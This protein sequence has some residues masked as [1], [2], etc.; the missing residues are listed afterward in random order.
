MD[1]LFGQSKKPDPA[2]QVREW[3]RQINREC[4]S[5]DR[6]IRKIEMEEFKIKQS[7]KDH[8]KKGNTDSARVLAKGLVK[9]QNG[10]LRLHTTKA[11]LNSVGMTMQSQL[12]MMRQAKVMKQSAQVMSAM[13]S[14]VC[15]PEI[16][17]TMSAMAR[18]MTKAGLIEEMQEEAF[19]VLDDSDVEEEA[20]EEVS[21][22]L[23]ELIGDVLDPLK[24]EDRELKKEEEEAIPDMGQDLSARLAALTN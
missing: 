9:S 17:A 6:Q 7:I 20:E 13:N 21:K 5:L 11:Q 19:S 3:K 23:Q 14:L 10:K 8:A 24:V 12:S 16:Q 2:E 18:E 4:R 1:R 15:I 22:V